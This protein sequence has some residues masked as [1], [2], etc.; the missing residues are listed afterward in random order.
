MKTLNRRLIF[1]AAAF[2]CLT[3][4]GCSSTYS[5][6]NMPGDGEHMAEIVPENAEQDEN[7]LPEDGDRCPECPDGRCPECPDCPDDRCPERPDGDGNG[8]HRRHRHGGKDHGWRRVRPHPIA[9]PDDG[10]DSGAD[11]AHFAAP[12]RG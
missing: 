10:G 8:M 7:I 4:T 11:G 9:P 2:L 12:E 6:R 3:F 5:P 1:T